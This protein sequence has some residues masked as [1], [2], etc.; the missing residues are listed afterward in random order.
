MYVCVC[1][2]VCARTGVEG[3]LSIFNYTLLTGL[4]DAYKVVCVCV[5]V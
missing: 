2:C 3:T 1:V 4:I 5:S